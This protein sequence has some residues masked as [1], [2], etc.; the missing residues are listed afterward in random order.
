MTVNSSEIVNSCTNIIIKYLSDSIGRKNIV[1]IIL[2]GSAAR[3]Q[4][5]YKTVYG[6]LYLESDLDVLVVVKP[7]AIMKSL[8]VIKRLSKKM[9]DDLR[10]N[11]LLSSV[12]FSVYT[13]K[14]LHRM[15]PS[16]IYQDLSLYG[17]VIFGKEKKGL[18]INYAVRDIP[19][20]DLYRLIFNRIVELLESLVTYENK[21]TRDN[22]DHVLKGFE[23]LNF[24]L[25]QT[26]FIKYGTL[27]FK[28]FSSEDIKSKTPNELRNSELFNDLLIGYQEIL[29]MKNVQNDDT[30]PITK[31]CLRRII[32]QV[33]NT[34]RELSEIDETCKIL[35]GMLFFKNEGL[36]IRFKACLIIFLNYF[37][38]LRTQDL[39]RSIL[40]I[41][42]FGPDYVYFVLYR[43]FLSSE[44][45]LNSPNQIKTMDHSKPLNTYKIAWLKSF[46]KYLKIW[47]LRSGG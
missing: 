43:L 2:T 27:T 21:I 46:E 32:D 26:L 38:I 28:R 33:N 22:F 31:K 41:M 36:V 11:F 6:K 47:K 12:S 37:G 20:D 4:E 25:I 19:L 15:G 39:V 23:K 42:R 14:L 44:N 17:K 24:A 8:I 7:I 5:T 30:P 3:N 9:T 18:F 34:L 29:Q 13:E 10:K 16:I 45:L 40:Y 35:D 1:S